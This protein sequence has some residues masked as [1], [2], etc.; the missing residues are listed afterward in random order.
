MV[1]F[2]LFLCAPFA[3][4]IYSTPSLPLLEIS[5]CGFGIFAGCVAANVF[6]TLSEVVSPK[7]FGLATGLLNLAGGLGAGT[8]IFLTGVLR[9]SFSNYRLMLIGSAL[10][11]VMAVILFLVVQSKF[12]YD[13][14]QIAHT[15]AV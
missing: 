10:A 7:N 8:A 4:A 9:S 11:M 6:A 15:R 2:G 13:R 1:A 14:M 12:D 5:A 3:A